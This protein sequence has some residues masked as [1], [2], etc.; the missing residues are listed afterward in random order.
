MTTLRFGYLFTLVAS[1]SFCLVAGCDAPAAMP[2]AT[3]TNVLR[4]TGSACAFDWQCA[5]RRCNAPVDGC[6]VCVD[7]R[8]LGER[9]DGPLQGCSLSATCTGGV[10]ISSKKTLGQPCVLGAKG[11]LMECDDELYCATDGSPSGGACAPRGV[12]GGACDTIVGCAHGADCEN[13]VCVVARM[14]L[15]GDSCDERWCADGLFCG[16]EICRPAT[17]PIGADCGGDH[18]GKD[19]CAPG[20]ACELTG[21]PPQNGLY[22]MACVAWRKEGEPCA[23][24][25]CREDLFCRAPPGTS[26]YVCVRR[27][28]AGQTCT[29]SNECAE[30]LEC[31]AGA[32]ATACHSSDR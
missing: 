21:G 26:D 31:R 15:E 1:A 2:D 13:G 14:G 9:C 23:T 6:G 32:C 24:S 10:C 29:Y 22:P 18:I 17:L 25:T 28:L 3:S 30:G 27:Q 5:T 20:S 12:L 7:I 16:Q 8:P 11:D 4:P 19:S